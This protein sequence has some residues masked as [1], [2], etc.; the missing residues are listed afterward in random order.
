MLDSRFQLIEKVHESE[1]TLVLRCQEV[2]KS[3]SVILK[4]PAKE[5]N[6]SETLAVYERENTFLQSVVSNHIIRSYGL[7]T[8]SSRPAIVLEDC[9]GLSMDGLYRGE[10]MALE[11]FFQFT[12]QVTGALQEL[13]DQGII[14]RDVN[15]SNMLLEPTTETIKLIDLNL[16]STVRDARDDDRQLSG[17]YAYL[18][19]EQTGRTTHHVDVMSDVYAFGV[20]MYE[21]LTGKRPF[22][23][24]DPL[25]M[26]HEHL[27]MEP[28]APHALNANLPIMVSRIVMKCLE[29]NPYERYQSMM[30]LGSDLLHCSEE[31]ASSQEISPFSLGEMDRAITI[32]WSEQMYGVEE[33]TN[34][35]LSLYDDVRMGEAVSILVSGVSGSG[36]TTFVSQLVPF[37]GAFV[38]GKCEQY[39]GGLP[40]QPLLQ[41]ME[42]LIKKMLSRSEAEVDEWAERL[43]YI[44]DTNGK[45]LKEILPVLEAVLPTVDTSDEPSLMDSDI[46]FK[47]VLADVLRSCC[48]KE[49]PVVLVIDDLQWAD[50]ATLQFFRYVKE[51]FYIPYLLSVGTYR[52]ENVEGVELLP[53]LINDRDIVKLHL[54]DLSMQAIRT[55]LMDAFHSSTEKIEAVAALIHQKTKGNPFF[56]RQFIGVLLE[57]R[58]LYFDPT[59]QAWD[60]ME[61]SI[62]NAPHTDNVVEFLVDQFRSLSA[63]TSRCLAWAASVG[64]QICVGT[65]STVMEKSPAFVTGAL[66][67][68]V[69]RGYLSQSTETQFEFLH[70]RIQQVAYQSLSEFERKKVHYALASYGLS[71]KEQNSLWAMDVYTIVGHLIASKELI[72]DAK[73]K[74]TMASLL[75]E[76][77]V[78]SQRAAA[79]DMALHYA[80]LGAEALSDEAWVNTPDLCFALH[81]ACAELSYL[82]GAFEEAERWIDVAIN[83]PLSTLNKVRLLTIQI[84]I[85]TNLTEYAD[86]LK[87]SNR[88]LAMLDVSIPDR[89]TDQ[90]IVQERKV[91]EELLSNVNEEDLQQLPVMSNDAVQQALKLISHTGP[92]SYYV[93]LNWFAYTSLR[94]IKLSLAH[95]LS[96]FSGAGFTAYSIMLVG[97]WRNV[98]E[99][100]RLGQ[101]SCAI[102]DQ[103]H[104][105]QAICKAYGSFAIFINH[106]KRHVRTSMASLEKAYENGKKSGD[107][108]Y[109]GFCAVA[110][111]DT[112]VST[113]VPLEE[114]KNKANSYMAWLRQ[115]NSLDSFDRVML[116]HQWVLSMRGE[117][118]Q[119][120]SLSSADFDQDTYA[121]TLGEDPV[122]TFL[123]HFHKLRAAYF[124]GQLKEAVTE[125]ALAGEMVGS[126]VGQILEEEYVYYGA[127]TLCRYCLSQPLVADERERLIRK[128]Q[129]HLAHLRSRAEECPENY[130]HRELLIQGELARIHGD[131]QEALRCYDASLR[132]AKEHSFV[133]HVAEAGECAALHCVADQLHMQA[134]WF[135]N[136]AIKAYEQWGAYGKIADM[137]RTYP[138]WFVD[139]VDE[140][141]LPTI[142]GSVSKQTSATERSAAL[143]L[144]TAIKAAQVIS[145]EMHHPQLLK[146]LL[147]VAMENA[148]AEKAWLF[149]KHPDGWRAE[150]F[151]S[152]ASVERP[153]QCPAPFSNLRDAVSSTIIEYAVRTNEWVVIDDAT[154]N[155]Q[156]AHD[157]YIRSRQP[158]SL[159]CIPIYQRHSVN[160]VLYMENNLIPNAF[161]PERKS[162]LT[163]IASQAAISLENAR[164]YGQL[165]VR[166]KERTKELEEALTSLKTTQR[167]LLQ[168][169][170]MASLGGLMAGIAHEVN[171][172]IGVSLTASS[173]LYD[174]TTRWLR[175]YEEGQLKKK[176]LDA[177]AELSRD[178]SSMILTNVKRAADL[179]ASF[180]KITVDRSSE[181]KRSFKVKAYIEDVIRSLSPEL[182]KTSHQLVVKGP[183]DME[184]NSYPGSF[185]QVITNLVMNAL[186]HAFHE[187]L[188]GEIT[189]Q[190]FQERSHVLIVFKD[191]GAGISEDSLQKIFDPFFTTKRGQGGTGL[192][193]H[194]VYQMVTETLSGTIS[195]ESLLG[196]GTKFLIHLPHEMNSEGSS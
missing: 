101:L 27:A 35:L 128:I 137:E 154:K 173:H 132:H 39:N 12:A 17:T 122:K 172:P 177:F 21:W 6:D 129:S 54:N 41:A 31:W 143:D 4:M 130:H 66:Q 146:V 67:E 100:F 86:V 109:A 105:A 141:A 96:A 40:Y 45:R 183:D 104:D 29:K 60:W 25:E 180:K 93:D 57:K 176:D 98:D 49:H 155:L 64:R 112:S 179:V 185:S 196:Q 150:A 164:L 156:F 84:S 89:I 16:A 83:K 113:A 33:Q 91:I 58:W 62:R 170:K 38:S 139:T 193:L 126:V 43:R 194:V 51:D 151:E 186:Q 85:K 8:I 125:E 111:V 189:I 163:M 97:V 133:Q 94:S 102:A 11:T 174:S 106:R 26:I 72:Q 140:T 123:F 159:L 108:V 78:L 157:P 9:F 15:P 19:P 165:N 65:L 119:P 166:V 184:I 118:D 142:K 24:S 99:G 116:M 34:G 121:A 182:K 167:E 14:H 192:G 181:E 178:A 145:K 30:S 70:D 90:D 152:L 74:L 59:T 195:C 46:G 23:K 161:T 168:K 95:G 37:G 153:V 80:S 3:R 124:F 114:V 48:F 20:T 42:Q 18:S 5:F 92:S 10:S 81:E 147:S 52:E 115:I 190:L 47:Y 169:E 71:A 82:C 68:G 61:S 131:G 2:E 53:A 44:A 138:E 7:R 13:H 73:E 188:S 107:L 162:L 135:F 1:D 79:F 134:R 160:T 120:G 77:S 75:L 175:K 56:V 87:I 88:A 171:T 22:T 55:M 63:D 50:T 69:K 149:M 28:D 36:K 117:T 103:L 158:R 127:L 76:A 144:T 136:E 191:N 32:E 187:Q 148:G 110:L